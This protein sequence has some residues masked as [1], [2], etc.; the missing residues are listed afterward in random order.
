MYPL[1]IEAYPPIPEPEWIFRRM[2]VCSVQTHAPRIYEAS[3]RED[4]GQMDEP[5]RRRCRSRG[6]GPLDT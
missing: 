5:V 1:E 6:K 2:E 4:A 3:Y